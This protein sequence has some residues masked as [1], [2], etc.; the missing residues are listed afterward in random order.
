MTSGGVLLQSFKGIFTIDQSTKYDLIATTN[1]T[2]FYCGEYEC[3]DRNGGGEAA[4]A[5]VSSKF[6]L[7][8]LFKR[9]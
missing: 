5:T 9:R 8:R 3:V 7:K 1:D 4:V 2:E 6:A